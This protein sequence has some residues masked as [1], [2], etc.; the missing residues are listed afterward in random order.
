MSFYK[1]HLKFYDVSNVE[2]IKMF[3]SKI[4]RLIT[5]LDPS[6]KIKDILPTFKTPV[7][8]IEQ[9]N[10]QK[11]CEWIKPAKR[12]FFFTG[13]GMS[14]GSGIPTYR[15]KYGLWVLGRDIIFTL[16][17]LFIISLILVFILVKRKVIIWWLIL[18]FCLLFVMGI[19]APV[20]GAF[21]LSTPWGWTHFPKVSWIVFKLFFFDKVVKA[22]LNDGHIFMKYL[23]ET[24][25]KVVY[26]I[27][28][29]VDGIERKV[30]ST[31]KMVHGDIEKFFCSNCGRESPL[32]VLNTN[33]TLPW[34]NPKCTKCGKRNMRTGCL[35]FNDYNGRSIHVKT[36]NPPFW[37]EKDDIYFIIGSS[38]H[39]GF[40]V[41][42]IPNDAKIIEINLN[43]KPT[44]NT[45][46]K[47]KD[48]IYFS[49]PQE[50]VLK[51]VQI[52]MNM[53]Y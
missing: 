52:C 15:G 8:N 44:T 25:N 33:K 17:V 14:A 6:F 40:G 41:S 7:Y 35:L 37:Y 30:S 28:S 38:N 32:L 43:D 48:Y 20:A 24:Q 47:T 12:V 29:N 31:C 5:S 13:A 27:T 42:S 9:D 39:V 3:F 53:K 51:N 19:I 23:M 50:K 22:K 36:D 16:F 46:S 10:I 26:V 18:L 34:I 21:A 4:R 2:K 11:I 49:A 1:Q 45:K